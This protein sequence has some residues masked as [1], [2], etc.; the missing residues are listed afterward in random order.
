MTSERIGKTGSWPS[1]SSAGPMLFAWIMH[2][3]VARHQVLG[4]LGTVWAIGSLI[5]EG[6]IAHRG[7]LHWFALVCNIPSGRPP[8]SLGPAMSTRRVRERVGP[9]PPRSAWTLSSRPMAGNDP[10]GPIGFLKGNLSMDTAPVRSGRAPSP[11]VQDAS[12]LRFPE[13]T[14]RGFGPPASRTL[15]HNSRC[16]NRKIFDFARRTTAKT[17][18]ELGVERTDR[19]ISS[20][21][22]LPSRAARKPVA[23]GE[24]SRCF[25]DLEPGIRDLEPGIRNP[26]SA[27]WNP[28]FL[29][30]CNARRVRKGIMPCSRFSVHRNGSH[31]TE[32]DPD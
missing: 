4:R 17:L 1:I 10:T 15:Y 20:I 16:E 23:F 9:V 8:R 19:R 18:R 26:E 3:D 6:G 2:Y 21:P 32:Q 31:F 27:I 30:G 11:I 5:I 7:S 12:T 22:R 24:K 28:E 13:C 25:R 14:Y 29:F